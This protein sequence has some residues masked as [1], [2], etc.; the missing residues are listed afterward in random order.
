MVYKSNDKGKDHLIERIESRNG[1]HT[2]DTAEKLGVGTKK[3]KLI[4]F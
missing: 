2:I 1:T 4:E 3:Y